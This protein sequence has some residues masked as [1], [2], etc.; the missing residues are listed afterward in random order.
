M[1]V[2]VYCVCLSVF[3]LLT[4]VFCER[5]LN[6]H[7]GR[8]RKWTFETFRNDRSAN[9]LH[10]CCRISNCNFHNATLGDWKLSIVRFPIYFWLS[11]NS[12]V[13][14]F[15]KD[16]FISTN[17]LSHVCYAAQLNLYCGFKICVELLYIFYYTTHVFII[18]FLY[19]IVQTHTVLGE[20]PLTLSHFCNLDYNPSLLKIIINLFTCVSR[21]DCSIILSISLILS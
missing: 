8:F 9:A 16:F 6:F 12:P 13:D 11:E 7:V 21:G 3:G 17:T 20:M 2:C 18:V 1:Y 10:R 15:V 4:V 19:E 14:S 5:L